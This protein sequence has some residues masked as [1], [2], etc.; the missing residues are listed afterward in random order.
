MN[1]ISALGA[2][3]A[4]AAL[5][6]STNTFAAAPAAEQKQLLD[7]AALTIEHMKTDPA[8]GRARARLDDAKAVLADVK[9]RVAAG[10]ARF[11]LGYSE[12]DGGSD[13]AAAK[14]RAVRDGDEWVISG[15]KIFITPCVKPANS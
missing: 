12:P 11:C 8:F 4:F 5:F 14:V 13:I 9:P 3:L 2:A 10:T 1:R 7:R 15:S 6:F